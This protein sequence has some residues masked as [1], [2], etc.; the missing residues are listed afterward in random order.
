[1]L[2]VSFFLGLEDLLLRTEGPGRD[3]L[4]VCLGFL[5]VFATR[6]LFIDGLLGPLPLERALGPGGGRLGINFV[7]P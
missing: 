1:M 3:S 2:T 6:F 5:W 4:E 7:E